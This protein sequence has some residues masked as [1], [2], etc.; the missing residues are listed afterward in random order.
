V[1]LRYLY[2]IHRLVTACQKELDWDKLLYKAKDYNLS[3]CLYFPLVLSRSLFTTKIPDNFLK[4]IAPRRVSEKLI[5][6]WI[7]KEQL[8]LH[9]DGIKFNLVA[10]LILCRYLYSRNWGDFLN[11]IFYRLL[12]EQ[13]T[14]TSRSVYGSK[15]NLPSP[16]FNL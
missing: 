13:K 14:E 16:N 2:D 15:L 3:T 1:Q 6:L 11:K 4:N 8:F 10:R 12:K 5:N 7:D 9:P